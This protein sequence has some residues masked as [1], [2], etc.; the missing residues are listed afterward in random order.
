M[1]I[2]VA[3]LDGFPLSVV[4][5]GPLAGNPVRKF[6]WIV[7]PRNWFYDPQDL[8]DLLGGDIPCCTGLL[9]GGLFPSMA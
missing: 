2:T 1:A 7:E 3:I 9:A 6:S 8:W 4:S 5:V